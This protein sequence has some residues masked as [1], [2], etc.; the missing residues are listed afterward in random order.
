MC[1]CNTALFNCMLLFQWNFLFEKLGGRSSRKPPHV[2]INPA[3]SCFKQVEPASNECTDGSLERISTH[4][5]SYFTK[6]AS[7]KSTNLSFVRGRICFYSMLAQNATLCMIVS[8]CVSM[9]SEPTLCCVHP[10]LTQ[11]ST[12]IMPSS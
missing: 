6:Y 12:N 10:Y 3:Y 5:E 2:C 4:N 8:T 1:V 7:N 11:P 9:S